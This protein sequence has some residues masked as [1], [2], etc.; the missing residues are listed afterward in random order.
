MPYNYDSSL[1]KQAP[2]TVFRNS[3]EALAQVGTG[4]GDE[5]AKLYHGRFRCRL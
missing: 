1:L 5:N 4:N 3:V 2:M